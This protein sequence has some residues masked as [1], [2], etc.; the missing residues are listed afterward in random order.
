MAI[1]ADTTKVGAGSGN[2]VNSLALSSFST[3]GTNR[4]VLVFSDESQD[5][6]TISGVTA[7]GLTFSK[8]NSVNKGTSQG[9]VE[10]WAAWAASQQTSVVITVT[11]TG[12]NFPQCNARTECW[13]GTGSGASSISGAIGNSGTG[14]GDTNAFSAS[15]TTTRGGSQVVGA[16]GQDSNLTPTAGSNQTG[17]GTTDTSTTSSS[18]SDFKQN[19]ATANS[20]TNV[21]MNGTFV[22]A[23]FWGVVVVE[24]LAPSTPPVGYD[25]SPLNNN[26]GANINQAVKRAAYF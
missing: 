25:V 15:L 23:T 2:G 11:Y 5:A 4:V 9:N 1:T 14:A 12:S 13:S 16:V 19:S 24:V 26:F 17:I 3:G 20:G 22:S 21:T 8:V 7:S 10:C 18:I 6:S